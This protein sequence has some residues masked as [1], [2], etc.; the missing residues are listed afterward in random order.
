MSSIVEK[1]AED[2]VSE[3]AA[4]PFQAEKN[5][6]VIPKRSRKNSMGE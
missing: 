1:A 6:R 5:T 3:D 2:D 4:G